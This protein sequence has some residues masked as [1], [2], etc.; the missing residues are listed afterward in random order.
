RRRMPRLIEPDLAAAGQAEGRLDPPGCFFD[1]GVTHLGGFQLLEIGTQIVTHQVEHRAEQ[2][3]LGVNDLVIIVVGGM[4][5]G[6]GRRKFEDQP[7]AAGIDGR[8]AEHVAKECAI[9]FGIIAVEKDMR[10]DKHAESL[11]EKGGPAKA[12][13][14]AADP[15]G[16]QSVR[17]RRTVKSAERSRPSVSG[18]ESLPGSQ[19]R[20]PADA[21]YQ[22]AQESPGNSDL[23]DAGERSRGDVPEA[24]VEVDTTVANVVT[25]PQVPQAVQE[26]HV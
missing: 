11:E 14:R 4:K 16:P 3:A 9:G 5:R 13:L 15:A 1:R 18:A 12:A 20:L 7:A 24:A 23:G 8:E 22:E 2:F 6:F 21:R 25:D 10:A 26:Q 19:P 17:P